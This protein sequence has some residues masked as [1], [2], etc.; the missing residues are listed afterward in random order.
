MSRRFINQLGDGEAVNQVFLAAE[1]QVRRNRT[2]NPY[3]QVRLS[4]RTGAVNGLMWNANDGMA[5][6]FQSGDFVRVEGTSQFYN[7]SLQIIANHIERAEPG[8]VDQ[9]EFYHLTSSDIDQLRARVTEMLRS[10]KNFHLR[11]LAECFLIDDQFMN[12]LGHAPA[13]IKNH[14]AFHGGLMDHVVQLMEVV[15]SVAPHYPQLDTDLILMGAFLHDIGK[16]RELS[17]DPDFAYTDEGQLI[18]HV[19][20]GVEMLGEKIDETVKLSGER[21]PDELAWRLKHMILSHH[22]QYEFGSPKV[23]MTIEAMALH[24]LDNLDAKIVNFEALMREDVNL[25][26]HWTTYFPNL[27]R[28]LYKGTLKND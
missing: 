24:L 15:L 17:Y 8:E 5:R 14:H 2:G 13:A 6:A 9:D 18:G 10:I 22:G 28:K 4:D 23:P 19:V 7:G 20:I 25:D 27:G 11:N 1:K 3:I 16:V 21:F 26:S 12:K